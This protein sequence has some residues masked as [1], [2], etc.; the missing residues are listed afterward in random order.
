[1]G[2]KFDYAEPQLVSCEAKATTELHYHQP[3][4]ELQ[5][6][7]RDCEKLLS[8]PARLKKE[9]ISTVLYSTAK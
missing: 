1:M 6:P 8:T 2:N 9:Y 7:P 4:V 5:I 3:Y